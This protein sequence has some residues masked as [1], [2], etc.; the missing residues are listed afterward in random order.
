MKRILSIVAVAGLLAAAPAFAGVDVF[1]QLGAP[2][3]VY[4]APAPVYATPVVYRHGDP[5]WHERHHRFEH[6]YHEFRDYRHHDY[7]GR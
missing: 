6:R 1:V 2:A 5:R 3:P 7:R 4:V